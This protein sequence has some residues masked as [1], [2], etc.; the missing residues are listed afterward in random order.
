[1]QLWNWRGLDVDQRARARPACLPAGHARSAR[2]VV[3]G[4]LDPSPLYTHRYPLERLADALDATRDRPDGFLKAL[5]TDERG[6]SHR[7]LGQRSSVTQRMTQTG[8]GREVAEH[9]EHASDA[10]A[11]PP[12]YPPASPLSAPA[13]SAGTAW[14][15]CWRRGGRGHADRRAV[16]GGARPPAALAPDA[17]VATARRGARAGVDGVVI[18]TPSALHAEQAVRALEA[19]SRSSARSRSAARPP[20][21]GVSSTPRAPPTACSRWICRTAIHR[22]DAPHPRARARPASSGEV[23]AVDLVFHNAY[24]PDKPWFY[25]RRARRRRLRDGPGRA[26]RRPRALDAR[27]PRRGASV[28][29]ASSPAAS[30]SAPTPTQVED[31][32]IARLDLARRRGGAARLLLALPAGQD[33]VIGRLLRH[34][35]GGAAQPR[36]L[37]L[38][39]RRRALPRHRARDAGLARPTT[40]AAAPPPLGRRLAAGE[41]FDGRV[42]PAAEP[43]LAVRSGVR[44]GDRLPHGGGAGPAGGGGVRRERVGGQVQRG[45]GVGRGAGGGGG[46]AER[47]SGPDGVLGRGCARDAGADRRGRRRPVPGLHPALRPRL[48]LWG[49]AAGGGRVPGAGC[50]GVHPGL[51]RA[52]PG[53]TPPA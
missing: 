48:H 47:R 17:A 29:A 15:R 34:R 6:T 38:R 10:T 16:G 31:Y 4:R 30:R 43:R 8:T 52:G 50:A 39:L 40:G 11:R 41:R 44:P 32:A 5:V 19:G 3:D 21:C 45:G 26:P 51:Q 7:G 33:A 35:G 49:R 24:G 23:Y 14:K 53:G 1:M 27:L 25:D 12:P 28:T 42:R 13:G 18:A 36:R 22:G 46:G 2:A 37:L 9:L 20:R